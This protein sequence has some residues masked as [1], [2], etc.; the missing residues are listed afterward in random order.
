M[1]KMRRF[2]SSTSSIR[3]GQAYTGRRQG[4]GPK[5]PNDE[6]WSSIGEND[7]QLVLQKQPIVVL[8]GNP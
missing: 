1:G 4:G 5:A 2:L 7:L 3:G 8:S 6:I